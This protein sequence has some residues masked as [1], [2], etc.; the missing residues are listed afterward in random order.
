M[1]NAVIRLDRYLDLQQAVRFSEEMIR[2]TPEP[3]MNVL[4][5]AGDRASTADLQETYWLCV[6]DSPLLEGPQI[7]G[8][9]PD[10]CSIR[11]DENHHDACGEYV[12]IRKRRVPGTR[13]A[14]RWRARK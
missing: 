7:R 14:R 5:V 11:H 12:L 9:T 8:G 1:M 2:N 3:D 13:R 4:I 10:W 6:H